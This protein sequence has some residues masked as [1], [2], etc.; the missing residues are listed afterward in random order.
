VQ[1]A[2][3]TIYE[4]P[5]NER[6][7]FF[8]RLEFLFKQAKASQY[9]QTVW[10]SHNTLTTLLEIL[11]IVSRI[12]M[13]TEVIKELDR[14]SA[15]LNALIQFPNI[16]HSTLDQLL[17]T[18]GGFKGQLHSLE[19]PLAQEL[20]ENEFLKL[21]IQRGGVPG[22]LCDFELPAYRQWLSRPPESR[23]SD[24]KQWLA[25]LDSLRLSIELVLK[26]VRESAE[27]TWQCASAGNYQQSLQPE[28]PF[29]MIRIKLPAGSPYFAEISAGKH[30]FTARFM[31]ARHSARPLQTSDDVEFQL[32]C[33]AL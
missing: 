23:V 26:M 27:P 18:L 8:M 22:G 3:D 33:C 24:L 15:S 12:D 32:S 13:K 10:D 4:Q 6:L 20:R 2:S 5:L 30:R 28:T 14:L 19:G 9:G 1:T 31:E 21:L 11:A 29:Q 7:R 16:N 17:T 25:K